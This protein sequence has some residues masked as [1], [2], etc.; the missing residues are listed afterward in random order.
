MQKMVFGWIA[1]F[2]PMYPT[3]KNP[4]EGCA[5]NVE[6]HPKT[7]FLCDPSSGRNRLQKIAFFRSV[8]TSLSGLKKMIGY[9]N[10]TS[11]QGCQM[12]CFHSKNSNLGMYWNALGWKML[13][14]FMVIWN[15]LWSFGIFYGGL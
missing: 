15:L 12:L 10:T 1:F 5:W 2:L 14:C 3:P 11:R 13:V 4:I 8:W 6:V 9:A 7:T